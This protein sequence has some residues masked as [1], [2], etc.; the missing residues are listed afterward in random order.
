M[1][2]VNFHL[3]VTPGQIFLVHFN[4]V[5]LLSFYKPRK[6]QCDMCVGYREN[7]IE[8]LAYDK[9]VEDKER[10]R[11]FKS[12][13][14]ELANANKSIKVLTMDLQQ[15]LLCPKSFASGVYYK[16]K[17]S[18]HNFTLYD[19]ATTEGYCYLWHEG[20]GGLDSDEFATIT[21]NQCAFN[22]FI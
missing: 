7:S 5:F 12:V 15:L 13:D 2:G 14:K 3:G 20:E 10:A 22:P 1:H 4:Q 17:L 11:Y 9:H 18:V 21:C 6:D 19:L 16:R 8:K